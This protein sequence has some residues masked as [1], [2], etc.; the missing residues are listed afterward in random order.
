ME[1]AEAKLRSPQTQAQ[2]GTASSDLLMTWFE[3]IDYGGNRTNIYGSAGPCDTAGYRIVPDF[4]WQTHLTS[5]AG[6]A[7]CNTA[8]F[9]NRALTY[10]RT[11][12]LPVHTLA[13]C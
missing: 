4:Y 13:H 3:H 2:V 10:A 8:R 9:T 6:F 5:A 11:F 1:D 7:F 12:G